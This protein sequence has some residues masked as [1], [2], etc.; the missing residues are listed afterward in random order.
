[1]AKISLIYVVPYLINS[2]PINVLYNIVKHLDR[3]KF[4]PIIITLYKNYAPAHDNKNLFEALGVEIFENSYSRLYVELHTKQIAMQLEEKYNAK[5]TIFHAHGYYPTLV[6]SKFKKAHTITTIHNI[7]DQDFR[8]TKGF[9]MG[10]FMSFMYKKALKNIDSCVAISDFMKDYYS[11]DQSLKLC[12]IY[13]GVSVQLRKEGDTI[14][15]KKELNLPI[16]K[17]I[18]LF[19][20]GFT[21]GKNHKYLIESVKTFKR[22]DFIILF[23]GQGITEDECKQ[24]VGDDSRFLFLGF[25]MDLSKYWAITDF[26]ISPSVSE[27]LPMAVLEAL[28]QGIPCLLSDIPPHREII[29][30]VFG[31]D[32]LCFSLTDEK[33][34]LQRF[35]NMLD[36]NFDREQVREKA[37]TLY[38]SQVMATNYMSLY[39]SLLQ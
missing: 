16:N 17:K 36:S 12:T 2:G 15:L 7:C 29:E 38:T 35:E 8:M 25:Q 5:D 22:N 6:L 33:D 3:T 27:G 20:A 34:L 1:M 10:N 11:K 24:I 26:M 19:P 21:H 9:L 30:R 32:S 37:S 14:A 18:L 13:N 28:V 31:S 39:S 4:N 23:A